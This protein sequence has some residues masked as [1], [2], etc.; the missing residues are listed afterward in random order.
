MRFVA[1]EVAFASFMKVLCPIL[2][3]DIFELRRIRQKCR[4][5]HPVYRIRILIQGIDT[6]RRPDAFLARWR[7]EIHMAVRPARGR[8][9]GR[10]GAALTTSLTLAAS[11]SLSLTAFPLRGALSLLSLREARRSG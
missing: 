9:C 11:L 7:T 1:L 5:S 4:R 10:S 8:T 3:R 2:I 6:R